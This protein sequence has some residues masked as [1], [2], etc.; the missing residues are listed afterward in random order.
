MEVANAHGHTLHHLMEAGKRLIPGH[1]S[2]AT[3]GCYKRAIEEVRTTCPRGIA[4]EHV[5]DHLKVLGALCFE[6]AT[7]PVAHSVKMAC[8]AN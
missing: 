5:M 3:W 2:E 1:F 4:D 8:A 6:D 7:A